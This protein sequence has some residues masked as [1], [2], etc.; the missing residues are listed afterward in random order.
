MWIISIVFT[1]YFIVV[2][3]TATNRHSEVFYNGTSSLCFRGWYKIPLWSQR[4]LPIVLDR[5]YLIE[6]QITSIVLHAKVDNFKA[7]QLE[8][9]VA[10]ITTYINLTT[11]S[12]KLASLSHLYDHLTNTLHMSLHANY[13]NRTYVNYS[14]QM[15][16]VHGNSES[17]NCSVP[18]LV[19]P[20]DRLTTKFYLK[21]IPFIVIF[22]SIQMGILLDLEVLKEIVRRPIAVAIGFFCQY[23]VMPLLAFALTKIFSVSTIV[24]FRFICCRLLSWRISIKSINSHFRW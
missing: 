12:S 16:D 11:N 10:M 6:N 20:P 2:S 3:E 7:I 23:G 13:L 24:W 9:N 17:L 19:L 8:H 14:I 1:S 22:V 15:T 4:I 5:T 21:S 18:V